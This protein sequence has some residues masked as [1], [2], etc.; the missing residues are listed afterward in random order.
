MDWVTYNL[1]IYI[2]SPYLDLIMTSYAL[3]KVIVWMVEYFSLWDIT[4]LYFRADLFDCYLDLQS[5]LQAF[6]W[7]YKKVLWSEGRKH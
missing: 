2:H 3:L 5:G 1:L 6:Q 4:S 7:V